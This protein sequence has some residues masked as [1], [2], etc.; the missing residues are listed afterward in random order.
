MLLERERQVSN[1]FFL[2]PI[3][4]QIAVSAG[5]CSGCT[6][7]HYAAKCIGFFCI[8]LN[9]LLSFWAGPFVNGVRG[10]YLVSFEDLHMN[11]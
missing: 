2:R 11:E 10:K 4:L 9:Q 3:Y 1:L 5:E 8:S 6:H 7:Y